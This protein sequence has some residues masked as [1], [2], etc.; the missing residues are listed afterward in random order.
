MDLWKELMPDEGFS[1]SRASRQDIRYICDSHYHDSYEIYY[2]VSGTRRQFV[3]HKIYDIQRG[4]LIMISRRVIHK[5]TAIDKNQHTR[6]LLSFTHNFAQEICGIMGEQLLRGV[7]SGVK[8][9][10]PD[11]RR[12]YVLGLFEKINEE[13]CTAKTDPYSMLM[14]KNYIT[15]LFVFI[16]RCYNKEIPGEQIEYIP[17]EKIQQAA[18]YICDNYAKHLT[19]GEVA[20]KVYMSETYFSKKFKWVTGLNF[21]EYLTSVRIKAADEML[22]E[23][24]LS[25]AAIAESCGFA[26]ANYFGDVFKKAKGV[27]PLKYRKFRARL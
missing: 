24:D 19:L 11:S 25:I 5:T 8:L 22:Q 16:N 14:V 21:R 10:V 15:Q 26:D 6:F 9:S 13:S 3:D 18:K 20:A 1:I 2:L 27:S 7:F 4:D 23:T 12:E 17:E